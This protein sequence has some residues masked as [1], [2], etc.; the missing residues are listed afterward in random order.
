MGII[1]EIS[2]VLGINSQASEAM[3]T[4]EL[5]GEVVEMRL[6]R[7]TRWLSELRQLLA[8]G[9][10][11]G[12]GY[13]TSF[14]Q[15]EIRIKVGDVTVTRQGILDWFLTASHLKSW[16]VYVWVFWSFSHKLNVRIINFYCLSVNNNNQSPAVGNDS[17]NGI[18]CCWRATIIY[19]LN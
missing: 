18:H 5:L 12:R 6:L 2:E 8:I 4:N 13:E 9:R 15:K 16:R 11:G 3:R 17:Q 7:W 14:S 19:E 1:V 10:C